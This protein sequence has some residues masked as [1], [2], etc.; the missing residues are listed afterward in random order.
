MKNKREYN[1]NQNSMAI[2]LKSGFWEIQERPCGGK[3]VVAIGKL[4]VLVKR[5][6]LPHSAVSLEGFPKNKNVELIK[7]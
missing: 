1:K 7:E 2:F 3:N 6:T 4:H 5:A